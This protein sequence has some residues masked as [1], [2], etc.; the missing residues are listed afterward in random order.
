MSFALIMDDA[1]AAGGGWVTL[2]AR[3]VTGT[4]EYGRRVLKL[5]PEQIRPAP[6]PKALILTPDERP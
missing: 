3:A 2:D 6:A 1:D 4:D 5:K